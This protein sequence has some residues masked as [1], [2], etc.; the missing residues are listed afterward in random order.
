SFGL[1]IASLNS[2]RRLGMTR[3]S[4]VGVSAAVA[5]VGSA[6]AKSPAKVTVP[7]YDHFDFRVISLYYACASRQDVLQRYL[8]G[9]W[10]WLI[11]QGLSKDVL[12]E[13]RPVIQSN[14]EALAASAEV[15]QKMV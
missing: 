2:K 11:E 10:D 4:V 13:A 12:E 8:S 7:K 14:R 3:R 1:V 6:H 9:N 5:A 15:L